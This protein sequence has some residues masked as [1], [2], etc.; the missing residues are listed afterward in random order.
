[1]KTE[2]NYEFRKRLDIVHKPGIFDRTKQPQADETVLDG[3]WEI[4]YDGLPQ[5]GCAALDLQDYLQVCMEIGLPVVKESSGGKAIFLEENLSDKGFD[6]AVTPEKITVSGN[7]RKG[8]HH[9]E[10]I[11]NLREAP[12]LPVKTMRSDP[13]FTPR[14]VHSGWA[15]DCF[16]DSHLNAISHA[17]FDAILLFVT[18]PNKTSHGYLDL[19]DLIDRAEAYGLGVYFYSYLNSFKHPDDPDAEEFFDRNF[20]SVFKCAPRAKGLILVGESCRFPSKDPRNSTQRDGRR[21]QVGYFPASDYPQ[22]LNAVK[23]AVRRYS[24]DADVVFWTYNWG[25]CPKEDR[26]ALIET[27]PDD[28]SVEVT[29]EMFQRIQYPNHTMQVPDY[30]ITFPGPGDYF[31]SEAEAL[32]KRGMRLYTISNTG[33]RTWDCGMMPYLPVPQ[34]WFKR[35]RGLLEAHEKWGLTGIMDSHHFGWFPGPIEECARW[36]FN[37]PSADPDEILRKIAVRDF[38]PEA[39]ELVIRGWQK[40]SDAVASYTPGFG[41]QCG[42]LRVG[43]S[44]P[45]IFYP[46]LYPFAEQN[47]HFPFAEY[48]FRGERYLNTLY[49]PE[50]V[51]GH[52]FI[53]RRL[54]EDLKIMPA[55]LKIWQEGDALMDQALEKVPG[56]KKEAAERQIG[57]G[58]FFGHVLRTMIGIKRWYLANRRLEVTEDFAEANAILDEMTA[59]LEEEKKNVRETIPIVEADSSL[60]WE[61]TL[62]YACDREHLEWKLGKLD[63]VINYTIPNYRLTVKKYGND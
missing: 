11:M 17:G 16:P 35:F 23:R 8:V 32:H 40:W 57:I 15:L 26:L 3:S 51:E 27:L 38:G 37:T 56:H 28:V 53:G 6:L 33:G 62:E 19:N 30:T 42:P 24:P 48:A 22:W 43:P 4:V 14:M 21:P 13:I 9:L 60:G 2:K 44:Y 5:K 52:T 63:S 54:R 50:H 12:Y 58:K 49:K 55:A 18:G 10:D 36:C 39:A 61:P 59:I 45:F 25:R 31:T 1:M 46:V 7:I 41:D 20:G 34:Q 29:Y 47:M